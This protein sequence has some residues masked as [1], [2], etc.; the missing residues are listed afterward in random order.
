MVHLFHLLENRFWEKQLARHSDIRQ[1]AGLRVSAVSV[2]GFS[3][4]S[5]QPERNGCAQTNFT[6]CLDEHYR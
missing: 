5:F 6:C 3:L 2:Q 1:P 4:K